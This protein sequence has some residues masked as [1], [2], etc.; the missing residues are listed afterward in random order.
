MVT[1]ELRSH[2][3]KDGYFVEGESGEPIRKT[4]HIF[5]FSFCSFSFSETYS[6]NKSLS[7]RKNDEGDQE[8]VIDEPKGV[9]YTDLRVDM[10]PKGS[11]RYSYVGTRKLIEKYTLIIADLDGPLCEQPFPHLRMYPSIDDEPLEPITLA[12]FLF[13]EKARVDDL[14]KKIVKNEINCGELR[15]STSSVGDIVLTS[16]FNVEKVPSDYLQRN[17]LD[18]TEHSHLSSTYPYKIIPNEFYDYDRN[19]F[20]ITT[21]APIQEFDLSIGKNVIN[22][23]ISNILQEKRLINTTLNEYAEEW[24]WRD[25]NLDSDASK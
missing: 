7:F 18:P 16:D 2:P 17:N 6:I 15:F 8:L 10:I 24:M 13:L 1:F 3:T 25:L 11:T 9:E 21:K 14:V 5:N 12:I 20:S 22:D 4:G 19:L 23:K